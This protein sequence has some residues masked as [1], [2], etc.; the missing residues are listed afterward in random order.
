MEKKERK[1]ACHESCDCHEHGQESDAACGCG[2]HSHV[3]ELTAEEKQFLEFMLSAQPIPVVRFLLRSSKSEH[4]ETIAMAPVYM[5]QADDSLGMVR[6]NADMLK[7]LAEAGLVALDYDT[8][9][10]GFD[11][12]L[13]EQS[14][15]YAYFLQTVEEAK[16]NSH[17]V[18]DLGCMEKGYMLL[19]PNGEKVAA[20]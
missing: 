11:Y 13:Y 7:V 15:A 8:L 19:T 14:E 5:K 2:C 1:H 10:E 20:M 12:S 16:E 17:F 6:D 18:F 4:F 9:M 3:V